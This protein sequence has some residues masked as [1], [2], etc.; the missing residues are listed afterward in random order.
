MS[1]NEYIKVWDLFVRIS[2]WLLVLFVLIAFLSGDEKNPFH[3]YAGYTVLGIISLRFAWGFIGGE[4][5]RF[6]NF[7][8]PPSQAVEYIKQLIKG[9]PKYYVGHNPAAGWM[10]IFLFIFLAMVCATGHMAYKFKEQGV[11]A[12][13]FN[14]IKYAYADSDDDDDDEHEHK[15]KSKESEFWEDIHEGTA[16]ALLIL[17]CLHIS[18]ALLSSKLHNEN[19]VMAMIKGK[20]RRKA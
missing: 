1:K 15:N 13:N 19:L 17:I 7:I 20:K 8:Y 2:H 11:T 10:V 14:I 6:T 9:K 18:G 3:I 4:Y 12:Q 16:S 5:A